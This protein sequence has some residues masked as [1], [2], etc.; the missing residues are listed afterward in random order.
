MRYKRISTILALAFVLAHSP[1]R[2]PFR[3]GVDVPEPKLIRKVEIDYPN[4]VINAFDGNG[5]V[6]LDILVNEQGFVIK[7]TERIYDAQVLE[8]VKAAVK[9]WRF[10]P[11]Y[12]R[13]KAVPVS[14]TVV[15]V[16]ALQD[17]PHPIDLAKKGRR[18]LIPPKNICVLPVIMDNK[19]NL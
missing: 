8:A 4:I 11:T 2:E 16:F 12:V 17:N 10:S 5:P 3:A 15:I 14:A 18:A 1:A 9:Q 7:M 19:G 6:V 13:G